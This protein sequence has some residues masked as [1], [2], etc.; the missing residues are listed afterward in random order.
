M[1]Q[2]AVLFLFL[3]AACVT[4]CS[5]SEKKPEGGA[6]A[7]GGGAGTPPGGAPVGVVISADA[8]LAPAL[9]Q[10]VN[11]IGE[12]RI[13]FQSG[14]PQ[15][16]QAAI[17]VT[18]GALCAGCY[19]LDKQGGAWTVT[20]DVLGAI[21]GLSA[22]LH[23]M[24]VRFNHPFHSYAP[25]ELKAPAAKTGVTVE[26]RMTLRGLHLHTLH[27][28]EAFYD[29]WEP[30]EDNF[31][32]A[33]KVLNWTAANGGNYVQW[34]GLNNISL[35]PNERESWR[36]HTRR[37][38]DA[39]KARGMKTGLGVQL[40]CGRSNLQKALCIVDNPELPE[41]ELQ[42][43]LE[44]RL[45]DIFADLPFDNLSLS[46]GE[47]FA[48][49]PE[50]FVA[51]INRLVAELAKDFPGMEMSTTIHVG[52]KEDQYVEYQ[53]KRVQY[54]F[55]VQFADPRL[56]PWVHT[57]MYFNLFEDAGGAYEH[58]EFNEHRDYLLDRLRK[59]QRVGYHPES[60]YWVSFDNS[61]PIYAPVY[62]HSRALDLEEIDK[63]SLAQGGDPL[64]EHS[65]FSSGWEWGYWINDVMTLQLNHRAFVWK[66]WLRDYWSAWGA[67]GEKAAAAIEA[68]AD[69]QRE[70]L[71]GKRLAAYLAGWDSSQ[72]SGVRLGIIAQPQR[73]PFSSLK[74][75]DA[76]KRNEFRSRVLEPLA[77]LA[78]KLEAA[79][80]MAPA[81][82]GKWLR[83]LKDG[84]EV[85][86]LRARYMHSL[87]QAVLRQLDGAASSPEL[88]REARDYYARAE[89][90]VKRRHGDLWDTG[91]GRVLDARPNATLYPHGYLL[92]ADTLC[93]WKRDLVQAE[94]AAGVSN[95][96]EP[97][98]LRI[99]L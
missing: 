41:A 89:T 95:N 3:A 67:D 2:A 5:S 18:K 87:F 27:P 51:M 94:F 49:Q 43:A 19:R 71:I 91:G 79:H 50:K 55:L 21:H 88:F 10:W 15:A 36:A 25:A 34:V 66:E 84:L 62:L 82:N 99:G 63:R 61:V 69:A 52:N 97:S 72:D 78:G 65:L 48:N 7:D 70:G 4:G 86:A 13:R 26:P 39:A 29:F 73:T 42:T 32:R 33:V 17:K 47:F 30:G 64:K 16:G 59:K 74:T 80:A 38:L 35:K 46:F 90:V 93:Y 77:V 31:Q 68:A 12:S 40:F 9:E 60:A 44:K 54:Y 76:A 14:G 45:K 56:I 85:T 23:S 83:E 1:K 28:I 98:C 8:E 96:P 37:I 58:D 75:M 81:S 92:M 11:W 6:P 57:V 24:G 20:A 53:G 22:L